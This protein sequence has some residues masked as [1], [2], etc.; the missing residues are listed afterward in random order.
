G[1]IIRDHIDRSLQ[2]FAVNLGICLITRAELR[3]TLHS[4]EIAC[5]ASFR[6]LLLSWI[7][8]VRFRAS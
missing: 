2:A 7:S 3:S 4:L 5:E 8:C 1:G 6:K